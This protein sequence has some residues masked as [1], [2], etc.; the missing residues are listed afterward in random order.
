MEDDQELGGQSV[1]FESITRC[2][3]NADSVEVTEDKG[4][5]M[6]DISE[7]RSRDD[8][9]DTEVGRVQNNQ[10]TIPDRCTEKVIV[11]NKDKESL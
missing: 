6:F 11:A 9:M 8:S 3:P 4:H 10:R 5:E 2:F 7:E 1:E